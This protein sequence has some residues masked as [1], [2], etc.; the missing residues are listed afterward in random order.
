MI[1]EHFGMPTEQINPFSM[2]GTAEVDIEK[3]I[4][5]FIMMKLFGSLKGENESQDE[6]FYGKRADNRHRFSSGLPADVGT[7]TVMG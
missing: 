7:G 2:V 6:T 4:E 3:L 5:L 1:M